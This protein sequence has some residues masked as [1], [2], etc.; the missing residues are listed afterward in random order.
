MDLLHNTTVDVS[1]AE[2]EKLVKEAVERQFAPL[3]VD[4]VEFE[5]SSEWRGYGQGEHQVWALKG[6]KVKISPES[7]KG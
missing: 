5:L 1:P 6:A 7:K 2:L 3:T 4:S